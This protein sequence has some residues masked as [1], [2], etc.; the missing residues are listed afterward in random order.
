MGTL[1]PGREE[2]GMEVTRDA[3]LGEQRQQLLWAALRWT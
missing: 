1:V 2:K 3:T